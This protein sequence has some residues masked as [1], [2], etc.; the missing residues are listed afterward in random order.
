MSNHCHIIV[1]L[2]Q[3]EGAAENFAKFMHDINWR[4]AL[5]FN[6]KYQRKGHFFQSRYRCTVLNSV[7]YILAC[8]R[9]IYRNPLRALMVNNPMDNV[10]GSYHHYATCRRDD[11]ITTFE[12]YEG[13]GENE[14]E[15]ARE[16]RRYVE[17]M[18]VREEKE[19]QEKLRKKYSLAA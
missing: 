3:S 4:F 16:F 12:G 17:S 6:K 19:L 5:T 8:Q 7:E 15:R 18:T 11:L 2:D 1:V 9:Y 13:F 10:F 14:R